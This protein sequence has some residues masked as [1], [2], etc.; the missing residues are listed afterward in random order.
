[1][2]T[3]ALTARL[4]RFREAAASE[5][6]KVS[7]HERESSFD[8]APGLIPFV[9][10]TLLT[11]SIVAGAVGSMVAITQGNHAYAKDAPQPAVSA[12]MEQAMGSVN[13]SR[14][15]AV[16]SAAKV[17][18]FNQP[19]AV[20]DNARVLRD[21]LQSLHT[22]NCKLR[23]LGELSCNLHPSSYSDAKKVDLGR[24]VE[25]G[26]AVG[27]DDKIHQVFL[28]EQGSFGIAYGANPRD[29][30]SQAIFV[31]NEF[32]NQL[33][34]D[35]P[36]LTNSEREDVIN[37]LIAQK[38]ALSYQTPS[39]KAMSADDRSSAA[40]VVAGEMMRRLNKDDSDIN[41]AMRLGTFSLAKYTAEKGDYSLMDYMKE[42]QSAEQRLEIMEKTFQPQQQVAQL[43]MR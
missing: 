42:I 30:S 5:G 21:S 31:D 37:F 39:E 14:F 28:A 38:L 22:E 29:K 2:A 15:V 10:R 17:T 4:E 18:G 43:R 11:L 20:S 3:D 9:K 40:D 33:R 19:V 25:T 35:T 27:L 7:V 13:A 24:V 1:M 32:L 12:R 36:Q 6:V 23:S 8:V 26:F 34:T 16:A 41:E